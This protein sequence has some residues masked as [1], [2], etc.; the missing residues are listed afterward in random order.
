MKHINQLDNSFETV[1]LRCDFNVPI[2]EGNVLNNY[3]IL[4]S[5]KTISFLLEKNKKIIILSH[6]KEIKNQNDLNE[7]TLEPIAKELSDLLKKE[8]YFFNK[9]FGEKL[10][11]EIAKIT[12]SSVILLENTRSMNYYGSKET[13]NDLEL[14]KYW[15]SLGSKFVFDA[16]AVSHRIHAST[17]G[18]SS[19]LPTYY[20]FLVEEELF[21]LNKLLNPEKRPFTIFMGGSKVES[22]LEF[23]EKILPICD[24]LLLG[25]GI[26]NSFLKAKGVD[27]GKSIAT[28]D[29]KTL[30]NLK[31]LLNKYEKKIII[32]EDYITKDN[33]ILDLD[34]KSYQNIIN[35]SEIIFAN[36]TVGYYE[37]NLFEKG[38]IQLLEMLKNTKAHVII[39]GGD[40]ITASSKFLYDKDYDFYS[41]GGGATLSYLTEKTMIFNSKDII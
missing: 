19:I 16:F 33:K 38:T 29:E 22:K 37:D 32:S 4:K 7:N 31:N 9:C 40:I 20:G 11:E 27:V 23:I 34:I 18:I 12:T 36:G 21:N 3:K 25:G 13:N 2:K 1:I 35:N 28:N 15:A 14:S 30:N 17:S 26:L 6:L 10:K 39:G 5:L 24:Y 41:T 8:V